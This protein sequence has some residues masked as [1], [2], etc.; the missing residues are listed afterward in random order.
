[1]QV[2]KVSI[3]TITYNHENYILD[4]LN[5]FLEQKY[6]GPIEVIIANDNSSDNTHKVISNFL[7]TTNIPSNFE[8]KYTNHPINKGMVANFI[9]ALQQA[10]GEYIALCEGDDYWIDSYKIQKQVEFLENNNDFVMCFT[11][12]NVLK[13]DKVLVNT[14]IKYSKNEFDKYDLPFFAPTLTR[15]IK[16]NKSHF[17]YDDLL[18][19]KNCGTDTLMT[20]IIAQKGKVKFLDEITSIYRDNSDGVFSSLKTKEKKEFTILTLTNS[21][22]LVSDKQIKKKYYNFI[23]KEILEFFNY[24]LNFNF[25]PILEIINHNKDHFSYKFRLKIYFISL[26]TKN[27]WIRKL[28]V[29]YKVKKVIYNLLSENLS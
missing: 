27:Q 25:K 5:S 8:I 15:L 23:I 18:K 16:R 26:I 20:V 21:V 29:S 12:R 14:N 4:A 10:T 1:M 24:K 6:K 28:L 17:E 19:Y 13:D 2:P 3:V 11:N 9:W 7:A 22:L